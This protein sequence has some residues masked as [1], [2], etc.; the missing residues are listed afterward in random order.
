MRFDTPF[1][2]SSSHHLDGLWVTAYMKTLKRPFLSQVA[3]T[4]FVFP[5]LCSAQLHYAIFFYSV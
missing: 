3:H 1:Q 4:L 5:K 2:I